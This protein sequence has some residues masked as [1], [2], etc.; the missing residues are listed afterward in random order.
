MR[1]QVLQHV[2]FEDIGSMSG[3]LAARRA[4]VAY[5]RFF[6][7]DQLPAVA[8]LDLVIAMGGPMSVNDE[9]THGWLRREKEFLREVMEQGIPLVGICL[10]AQLIASALGA[11]V[12]PGPEKEIGWWPVEGTATDAEGFGFPPSATVFHW[13]GETFD[14]PPRARRLAHSE[15][16]ANQAFQ[17]DRRTIGLQFHL[18]TTP[19]S[20]AAIVEHS[21]H[22]LTPG[23]YIQSEAR[24]LAATAAEYRL[25]HR[26]MG[27][28]LDY[29][30]R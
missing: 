2:P 13:H 28:V 24:I 15:G 26:L 19:E 8:G 18:E 5:T 27:E 12:Y 4:E 20:A 14:L 10:G 29:V 6:A 7:A 25:I 17:I 9:A 22:E 11:R 23:R 16:C 3:W 30:T 1:V 21:R